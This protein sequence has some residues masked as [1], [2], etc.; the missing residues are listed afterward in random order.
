MR[1]REIN[2][3]VASISK[4]VAFVKDT[5]FIGSHMELLTLEREGVIDKYL[6]NK[7]S[8]YS[9]EELTPTNNL[10]T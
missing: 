9:D 2:E 3:T 5:N 4:L 6:N 8:P 10:I 7:V 1:I